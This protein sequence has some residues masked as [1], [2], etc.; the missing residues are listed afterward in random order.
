MRVMMVVASALS[1][2]INEAMAKATYAN[3]E[4][5]NF[6]APLTRSSGSH[7]SSRSC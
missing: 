1:Y 5:M 3:A 6:E 2:F 4:T 7:R